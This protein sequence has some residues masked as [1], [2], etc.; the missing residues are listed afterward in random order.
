[1]LTIHAAPVIYKHTVYTVP[2]GTGLDLVGTPSS[3]LG[4]QFRDPQSPTA[5]EI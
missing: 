1:M 3:L 4:R 2:P 5:V